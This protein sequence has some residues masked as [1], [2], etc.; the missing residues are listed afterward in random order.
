[1]KEIREIDPKV[2]VLFMSGY[3]E[4][5]INRKGVF[6]DEIKL[7]QKPIAPRMLLCKIKELLDSF[8]RVRLPF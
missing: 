4:Q 8:S 2:P 5:M 3:N 7:I 1:M 6:S